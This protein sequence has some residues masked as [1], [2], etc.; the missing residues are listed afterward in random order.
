MLRPA[1]V[2]ISVLAGAGC[3]SLLGADFDRGGAA[4]GAE[5][6]SSTND[7][8]PEGGSTPDRDASPTADGPGPGT[9]GDAAGSDA[10]ARDASDAPG[11]APFALGGSSLGKLYVDDDLVVSVNG[12]TA[13]SDVGKGWGDRAPFTIT[14]SAGDWVIMSFFDTRGG[15]RGH[16]EVWLGGPGVTT[17]SVGASFSGAGSSYPVDT[18]QPFDILV[19]QLPGPGG[20]AVRGCLP[21][22]ALNTATW[23]HIANLA[24]HQATTKVY[25]VTW[26]VGGKDYNFAP[27]CNGWVGDVFIAPGDQWATVRWNTIT[28]Q[29]ETYQVSGHA[30]DANIA[31]AAAG[32][33]VQSLFPAGDMGLL[34][35]K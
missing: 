15:G 32:W 1:F 26:A 24:I 8:L 20:T 9:Q 23:P 21:D 27:D 16:A 35:I 34:A 12:V 28:H 2:L 33:A 30:Y 18:I 7:G 3:A 22:I 19:F 14:G 25:H 13:Y 11:S 10:T 31:R 4:D 6:G 5:S 29:L 17:Q